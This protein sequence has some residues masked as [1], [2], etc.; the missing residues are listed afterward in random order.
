MTYGTSAAEDLKTVILRLRSFAGA[1]FGLDLSSASSHCFSFVLSVIVSSVP[2]RR[3]IG[4]NNDLWSLEIV[5]EQY[6]V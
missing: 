1:A 4:R 3:F 5:A 6:T 2:V